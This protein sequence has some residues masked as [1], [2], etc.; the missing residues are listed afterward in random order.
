MSLNLTRQWLCCADSFSK[1]SKAVVVVAM[2]V[3]CSFA[4]LAV[5]IMLF[6]SS[7]TEYASTLNKLANYQEAFLHS[8]KRRIT[9]RMAPT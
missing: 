4:S 3:V 8:N 5:I 6:S 2:N 1:D 9:N 7:L